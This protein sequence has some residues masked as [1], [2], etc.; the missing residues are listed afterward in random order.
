MCRLYYF[1]QTHVKN[2]TGV[3]IASTLNV[4]ENLPA[5][6]LENRETHEDLSTQDFVIIENDPNYSAVTSLK[7]AKCVNKFPQVH[8]EVERK[9]KSFGSDYWALDG[10]HPDSV[11]KKTFINA[12]SNY[13]EIDL[14]P[15]DVSGAEGNLNGF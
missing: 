12:A 4:T 14:T 9:K 8:N 11:M 3:C 10:S 13:E 2:K 7:G 6:E 15:C 1:I 5:T